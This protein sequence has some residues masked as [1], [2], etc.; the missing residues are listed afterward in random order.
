MSDNPFPEP[1]ESERTVI[2]RGPARPPTPPAAPPVPVAQ[3]SDHTIIR[4]SSAPP[5]LA[6]PPE[7]SADADSERTMIRPSPG[8]RR[9]A[10][11][12]LPAVPP[13]SDESERTVIR[14]SPGG[15]RPTAEPPGP[16]AA[17]NDERT[18][19]RPAPGGMR[20]AAAATTV[21][22]NGE[23]ERTVIR[24]LPGGR[25]TAPQPASAAPAAFVEPA[26]PITE[27]F[28]APPASG[29][30][31]VAAAAP[32][33][34]L[35]ARLR[36]T[37][38]QPDA[39]DLRDRAASAMQTFEDKARAAGVQPEQLRPAHYAL[40]ASID[41]VVVNTPWGATS[42]WAAN[43]LAATFHADV[44]SNDRFFDMLKRLRENPAN[45]L[46]LLEL[47]YF[48][49]SLGFMGRYRHEPGGAAEIE[50]LRE[51]VFE[52]LASQRATM[53]PQLSPRWAG[54]SAPYRP[55]RGRI[56]LWV[57][58]AVALA[59]CGG[60]FGWISTGLNAASDDH[61]ARMLAAAPG[62]MPLIARAAP[63]QPPPPPPAPPEP[64]IL[65]RLQA[66]LKP[67]IDKGTL[68]VL[69]TASS[70]VLRVGDRAL[71]P[72]TSATLQQSAVPL[73]EK[74]GAEL[75]GEPGTVA[76]IGY[77]DNQPIRTVKFPSNFQLSTARAQAVRTIVA[78]GL[79]DARRVT[80]EGRADEDPVASNATPDGREQNRRIEIVLH[81]PE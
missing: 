31:L 2:R 41:D 13:V 7:H 9:P 74:I 12:P 4:A 18:I 78:R 75:K 14:P 1:D 51:E 61:Y 54:V 77:T 72:A 27:D 56:P 42:G 19:I 63:V 26:A 24:P 28:E 60:L 37:A 10:P 53:E 30:P 76:V 67:E 8:G 25:R 16:I 11:S 45:F 62:H 38:R 40:C 47:I 29:T 69:G 52:L 49:L 81:R 46:P 32:L 58:G 15:R 23:G 36:N 65:D 80:A 6:F 22:D 35:L 57:I 48:C 55:A 39:G 73:L 66:A 3:E 34:Q 17:T 43:S 44:R 71:F 59:V 50:R 21:P 79:G 20:P 70:P 33:L 68:S 5:P 64:T